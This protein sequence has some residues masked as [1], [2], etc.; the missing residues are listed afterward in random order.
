MFLTCCREQRTPYM[1]PKMTS[2]TSRAPYPKHPRDLKVL[3][4][5]SHCVLGCVPTHTP[6]CDL[7]RE[8]A[9]WDVLVIKAHNDAVVSGRRGEVGHGAG[10]I[11]VVLAGD[12]RL[13]RALHGQGQAPCGGR[14]GYGQRSSPLH[15]LP[16]RSPCRQLPSPSPASLVT[17][18]KVA[19]LLTMPWLRPGP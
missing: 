8:G 5:R 15:R 10:A 4:L 16:A 14:R 1:Y 9:P 11:L 17:M 2:S 19:G 18:V 7:G 3:G 6:T 12:L 13:G